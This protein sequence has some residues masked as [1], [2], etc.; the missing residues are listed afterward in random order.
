MAE[1]RASVAMTVY[2]GEKY[3]IQ[4][5][6]SIR[7]QT[8]DLCEVLIIDDCSS[9]NTQ[10]IVGSYIDKHGLS[11]WKI[12][13]NKSNLG[14]KKNFHKAISQVNGD[15]I[16]FSDQDDIWDL[17]KISIMNGIF[18]QR[19]DIDVLTCRC[20]YI[21]SIGNPIV[22]SKLEIPFGCIAG[23]G[24]IVKECFNNKFIY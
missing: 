19:S 15:I 20:S 8:I 12:V 14:W 9:D 18:K 11:N 6:D 3:L 5:M 22:V 1:L 17:K 16:Y 23:N 4:Q 21:D 24:D 7:N 2:N 10:E 13:T